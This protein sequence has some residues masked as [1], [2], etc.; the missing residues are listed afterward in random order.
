MNDYT[1]GALEA[2]AWAQ[3]LI[4][5]LL[6]DPDGMK[7]LQKEIQAAK[8]DI[9]SGVGVDFRYRLRAAV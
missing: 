2:L 6:C 1:R 8:E 7:K 4:E 3:S 5:R 9:L